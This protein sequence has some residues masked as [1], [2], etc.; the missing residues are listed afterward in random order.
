MDK[1]GQQLRALGFQVE[2]AVE[3]GDVRESIISWAAGWHAD[4]ILLGSGGHRVWGGS[5]SAVWRNRLSDMRPAPPWSCTCLPRSEQIFDS[6]RIRS[7]AG[8]SK[9]Q[10]ERH[11]PVRQEIG[12][13]PEH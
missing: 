6:A 11:S 13:A 5:C 1:Y 12:N 7:H 4:V 3:R 8:I 10:I 2:T 9:C